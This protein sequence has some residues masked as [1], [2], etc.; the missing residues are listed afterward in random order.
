MFAVA[1]VTFANGGDNIGVYM[2][3]FAVAGVGGLLTYVLVFLVLVAA[4][5]VAG[6]FFATRPLVAQGLSRWGH[7]LL[8]IVLIGIGL[9]ILIEG[10]AF[11]L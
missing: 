6:H 9:V 8:P 1:A 10:H 5:C 7:L 4:W 11:G 2:P 3:V